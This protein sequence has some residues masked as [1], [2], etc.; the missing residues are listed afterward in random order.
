MI[1]F[2]ARHPTAANLFM[3][4]F[5]ILGI[6]SL[7]HLKRETFP[8]FS[9]AY[10][11][12]TV[13]YPG[14][15]PVEI[16]QSI[17]LRLEDAIDGLSNI[18]EVRC[19]AQEG[20]TRFILKLTRDAEMSRML[21]DVK[22]NIDAIDDFPAEV[23]S[24]VVQEFDWQEPV[25][26][27]AVIAS[28]PL[29]ELKVYVES[30]KKIL[31]LDYGVSLVTIDGFSDHQYQVQLQMASLHQ[32]GMSVNTIADQMASQVTK[33]P[34]GMLEVKNKQF[35]VRVDGRKVSPETLLNIVVGSDKNGA[36]IHLRDI[37]TISDQFELEENKILFDGQPAAVLNISKNKQ[38]D[39]LR[40]KSRVADFIA[41]Q[42]EIAP[43][44]VQ[45]VVTDDLSS[46]LWDRLMMMVKNG[47]QGLILVFLTMWLFFSFRYS[48]W[49]A[50]GLP[51]AFLGGL[52]FMVSLGLSINIMTLVALL[53]AI[54]IMMDD[55]IVISESVA[56]HMSQGLAV[57]QAVSQGVK[58]VFP[59]VLSSYLT[60]ASIFGSLMFLEGEIGIVLKVI[61]QV[62]LLI[63]SISLVE[64]FWILPFH[65]AHSLHKNSAGPSVLKWK[66]AFLFRFDRFRNDILVR[67]VERV[68]TY[69]YLFIGGIISLLLISIAM[70]VVGLVRFQPFPDIDGD[71]A[72]ARLILPPGSSLAQTERVVNILIHTAKEVGQQWSDDKEDGRTLI[73]HITAQYNK[74][75]DA[76][77]SGPHIA[78]VR[79]DLMGAEE[80]HSRI[81]EFIQAWRE[82][83]GHIDNVLSLQFKQPRMGPGGRALEIRLM[84]DDIDILKQAS[85]DLQQYLRSINGVLNV[86]DDMRK[87]KEEIT[88]RL[89][90]GA[91]SY[92]VN[93]RMIASQL[94][95]ALYGVTADQIQIG[96]ENIDIKVKVHTAE[97]MSLGDLARLPIT[98]NAG[99]QIPLAEI[100]HF[101]FD[102]R[103]ARI[104]RIDGLRSIRILGDLNNRVIA[105]TQLIRYFK[106]Q[107]MANFIKKY[108]GLRFDF[109]GESR[110]TSKTGQSMLQG[111]GLG[112]F[113]V[114]AILSFQFRS[115]LSPLIVML[116]I[117][118]A[119]IGVIWGHFFLHYAI[120]MPSIMGFISLSGI[121]VNDSIL[122]VQYI[123]LHLDEGQSVHRAAV[124]ASKERFRAVF[125]TSLT[126]TMGLLPL[127]ME[128]SLQAQV[129]QPLVISIVF[130][131]VSSTLLVLFMIPAA[132]V[133]LHD[134][135]FVADAE[136]KS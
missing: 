53:M 25:V 12:A 14:A 17:C 21:V 75:V 78:T 57:P 126:T 52:F 44:G 68:V 9:P 70:I 18:E 32:L 64:A 39:A 127:L 120:S 100:A 131:I 51:V 31:K 109:E 94:R 106:Q 48:F 60:T 119:L 102:R 29:P 26:D 122:L 135:G 114:F 61:P 69:R 117:P 55:A 88:V 66:Q 116:V 41:D 134:F 20:L 27:V 19:E 58:K 96:S 101:E 97:F 128:T 121:V 10:L 118:L 33:L 40:I 90:D 16:E 108:P 86:I 98:L 124:L 8:E 79:L 112:L 45:F 54:G 1:D 84:H 67:Y 105:S 38:D 72:E 34:A 132:Y 49:V 3:A 4:V 59:G 77:E 136:R 28:L 92:G 76:G 6:F 80:R 85:L 63:L 107:Q 46:V 36:L 5:I 113:G 65:L 91:E 15:S 89:R 83:V 74:H 13:V 111:F 103:Y 133:V 123:Q 24:V 73:R 11:V 35:L 81:D 7:P 82:K 62:L 56:S 104:Q 71:L 50:A 42:E 2:F 30:L 87:G 23:E 115:Y 37:A 99:V 110:D 47:V 93:T 43:N 95:A 129:I 22:S 125:L 130:G